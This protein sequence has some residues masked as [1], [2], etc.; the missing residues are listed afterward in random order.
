MAQTWESNPILQGYEPSNLTACPVC[1]KWRLVLFNHTE[2]LPKILVV[3]TL[4]PP[5]F[6]VSVRAIVSPHNPKGEGGITNSADRCWACP[7]P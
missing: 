2:S 6:C 5:M 7:Q 1:D 4:N 3:D